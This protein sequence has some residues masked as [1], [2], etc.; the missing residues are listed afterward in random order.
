M[1]AGSWDSII[2][3]AFFVSTQNWQFYLGKFDDNSRESTSLRMFVPQL[4]QG[5]PLSVRCA[6]QT[7][8]V[9]GLGFFVEGCPAFGVLYVGSGSRMPEL[10]VGCWLQY[11]VEV[12]VEGEV[13]SCV[14]SFDFTQLYGSDIRDPDPTSVIRIQHP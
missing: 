7:N 3:L 2:A 5:V 11:R 12:H 1:I 8:R 14:F 10:N 13:D 4:I 6:V 9:L